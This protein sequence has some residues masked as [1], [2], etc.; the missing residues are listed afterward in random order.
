VSTGPEDISCQ[1]RGYVLAECGQG[2][3]DFDSSCFESRFMGNERCHEMDT[4]QRFNLC[5]VSI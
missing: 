4:R 2:S 3:R 5:L 1:N